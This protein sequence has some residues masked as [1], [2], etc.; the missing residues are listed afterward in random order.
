MHHLICFC[1]TQDPSAISTA[2]VAPGRKEPDRKETDPLQ[3]EVDP[4]RLVSSRSKG[5]P[6]HCHVPTHLPSGGQVYLHHV[7]CAWRELPDWL[8]THTL[9]AETLC[10]ST[11]ATG[12]GENIRQA[13]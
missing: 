9:C 12:D 2:V 1:C 8:D 4:K 3:Q 5:P 10:V 11:A 7:T 6:R 13:S